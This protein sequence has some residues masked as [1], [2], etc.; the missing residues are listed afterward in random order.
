MKILKNEGKIF[1]SEKLEILPNTQYQATTKIIAKQGLPYSSYFSVIICDSN[2]KEIKRYILWITEFNEKEETYTI[3]FNSGP[4]SKFAYIG[5]RINNE[6]PVTSYIEI[7][8]IDPKSLKLGEIKNFVKEI[9]DKIDDFS[10]PK[11]EPLS[12]AD[13]NILESKITW[14]LGSPRTGT[15]WLG[16][17]LLKHPET[18]TWHE[19]YIGWHLDQLKNMYYNRHD[20]FFSKHHKNNWLP[21][22]RKLILARTYSMAQT[23]EKNVIIKEPNGSG[24]ADLLMECFPNSRL[25]FLLRDGRDVVDSQLDTHQKDSWAKKSLALKRPEIKNEKMRLELIKSY[26]NYWERLTKI[27]WESFQKHQPQLRLLVKY[28]ELRENTFEHLKKIYN[29]L[30]IEVDDETLNSIIKRHDFDNIP[31]NQKGLGKFYRS[32]SP[33]RWKKSFNEN[34]K[35]E[36]NLIIGKTLESFGYDV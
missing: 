26:A 9:Y 16:T 28:E 3:I 15:T 4:N 31:S 21:Q 24:A 14:I 2:L 13:E 18:I 32:A 27:V 25:I 20:Y 11:L 5:Y 7:G 17:Q 23:L 34:E 19:P 6:T 30:N 10:V 36:M 33:G 1:N 35:R 22:L 12:E 8:F 29:F